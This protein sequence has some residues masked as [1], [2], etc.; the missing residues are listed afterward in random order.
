MKETNR[1]PSS[2]I[3][4]P[5]VYWNRRAFLRAGLAAASVALT[6]LVYR[7]LNSVETTA[8]DTQ[9]LADVI[10]APATAQG[11]ARGVYV[12]EPPTSLDSIANYNNFY[13]FTT[14]RRASPRRRR[15]SAR[16]HGKWQ[17]RAWCTSPGFS[18]LT[19]W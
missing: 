16:S 19:T 14:K 5:E 3:T 6:G 7:R 12:D 2:E 8:V 18:I 13:E 11:I 1:I 4:P 9:A 15:G 10:P 17:S